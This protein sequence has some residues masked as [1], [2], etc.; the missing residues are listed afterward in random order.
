MDSANVAYTSRALLP[1][2]AELCNALGLTVEEYLYFCQLTDSYT[3]ERAKEYDL[4][5]DIRNEPATLTALAISL[6]VGLATSAISYLLTPKPKDAG[7]QI[8][9]ADITGQT[10]F[11]S[12]YGFDSLQDLAELGAVLPLIFVNRNTSKN[13]G[14]IRAK[15]MLI[16]SQM[17]SRGSQQEL[18]ALMTLGL[19]TLAARPDIEGYAVGDQLL[20]NYSKERFSL[21]FRASGGRIS[22]SVDKYTS[23]LMPS[24]GFDDVFLARD[25]LSASK[26]SALFSGSRT[27]QSQ[28]QFGCHSPISNGS[29]YWISYDLVLVMNDA[30]R[31]KLNKMERPYC[32]RQSMESLNNTVVSVGSYPI[33]ANSTLTFRISAALEAPDAFPPHGLIDVNNAI[34]DRH[35]YADDNINIGSTYIFG[36]AIIE[37]TGLST[38]D[39]WSEGTSKSFTF[40]CIEAGAGYFLPADHET[41]TVGNVP[42]GQHLQKISFGIVSNNRKCDQTEIGIKSTV[43]KRLN[44]FANVNSQPE[45]SV[46]ASY[47]QNKTFLSLGKVNRYVN[48]YS[49]FKVEAREIGSP[50]DQG[51]TDI[52][53]GQ[54]FAVRGNSPQ[55]QYN[56]LRIVHPYR[57]YEFRVRPIP[58]STVFGAYIGNPVF[59]LTGTGTD[60]IAAGSFYIACSGQRIILT[61]DM[62]SNPEFIIGGRSTVGGI[63]NGISPTSVGELPAVAAGNFL[64]RAVD[65][66]IITKVI[67]YGVWIDQSNTSNIRAY[68]DAVDVTDKLSAVGE[69]R[70]GP[71]YGTVPPKLEWQNSATERLQLSS[72]AYYV[73]VDAAGTFIGAVWNN[74][75]VNAQTQQGTQ[76]VPSAVYRRG[77]QYTTAQGNTSIINDPTTPAQYDPYTAGAYFGVWQVRGQAESTRRAFWNGTEVILNQLVEVVPGQIGRYIVG[78][79]RDYFPSINCDVY[80]IIRQIQTTVGSTRYFY[81]I[82]NGSYTTIEPGWN[83]YSIDKYEFDPTKLPFVVGPADYSVSGGSGLGLVINASSFAQGQWQW[84]LRNG[85]AGYKQGEIVSVSFPDGTVVNLTLG[86]T[87]Q[88]GAIVQAKN[89]NPLDAIA[90]YWKY[91]EEQTSHADGPEHEIVYVNEQVRQPTIPKYDDMALVGLRM[92]A[93]RD[94]TSLGQLTAYCKKGIIVERLITDAGAFTNNLRGPSNNLPEIAYNLLV[95]PIIGA[96]QK[97]ARI[98]VDRDAMQIAAKFCFAN[99]FTWDGIV[100]DRVN[101]REWIFQQAAYCLLD[102]TIIG[103]RFALVPSVPYNPTSFLIDPGQQVPI[104]ALFTDGNVRNLSVTWL[105]PE[106]RRMFKAV[107]SYRQ[108]I[109]NGFGNKKTIR[110]RLEDGYGGSDL[111]IEEAF[112][113]TNFCTNDAHAQIFAQHI[114]LLRQKVDH[115][116]SFQTTPSAAASL[117]PGSYFKFV[118]EATH[119]SRFNNGS[120]DGEGNIVSTST[121]LDGTH[122]ILYWKSGDTA[123]READLIVQD[124]N[125][126]VSELFNAVFTLYLTTAEKRVYKIETLAISEDGFV[127][128]TATHQPIASNGGLATIELD[129]RQF[130]VE[131]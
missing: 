51:W 37:C 71:A 53:A 63:V 54:I 55:P 103:G 93:G 52:S 98:S 1:A 80:T 91:E 56:V 50:I 105:S 29:Q 77:T 68:W 38:E 27:P 118:S 104:S 2:E 85:G 36:S 130:K 65:F 58:G 67:K 3:G 131:S 66:D 21:Y 9:T 15:A 126:T 127:D 10:K 119:T 125:T 57:E 113:L 101:L 96:G 114:L 45:P 75:N 32:I 106:E 94:W 16:W 28:L 62:A 129:P 90:D 33:P 128:V 6:A 19:G 4:V 44:S 5:P 20:K 117:I 42:Y 64:A 39:P 76:E 95:D 102:F 14:G 89:L 40:K 48:R 31:V 115:S 116:V 7:T 26:Y 92:L 88:Q 112:D 99:G 78:T 73:E 100:G 72:P 25:E 60:I 107:V 74:A 49:F 79:I 59:L 24:Q 69:Y 81:S 22:E 34:T 97:V 84:L 41:A 86:I 17:L 70:L 35:Y 120:I 82:Q 121:L 124:G 47:A 83:T 23:T 18:K 61:A 123:V 110:I 109:E 87:S 30:D 108:E 122:R 11:A 43:W 13:I 8:K 111:D 12:L 46:V